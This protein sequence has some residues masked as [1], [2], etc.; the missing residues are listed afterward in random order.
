MLAKWV[1][2]PFFQS[3]IVSYSRK[4]GGIGKTTLESQCH[5]WL[6]K[7]S[8]FFCKGWYSGNGYLDDCPLSKDDFETTCTW[9]GTV[10]KQITHTHTLAHTQTH[11]HIYI[12]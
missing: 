3:F 5:L 11:T 6:N 9:L 12:S 2:Q 4:S 1:E 10:S 7:L 8:T